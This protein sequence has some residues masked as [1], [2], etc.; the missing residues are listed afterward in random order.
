MGVPKLALTEEEVEILR[1]V[2]K[3]IECLR[4]RVGGENLMIRPSGDILDKCCTRTS[5]GSFILTSKP[6]YED[7]DYWNYPS[8][9]IEAKIKEDRLYKVWYSRRFAQDPADG[10]TW[11]TVYYVEEISDFRNLLANKLSSFLDEIS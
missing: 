6:L 2:D 3:L 1:N 4:S 10:T 8:P 5:R 9:E 7:P 11:N